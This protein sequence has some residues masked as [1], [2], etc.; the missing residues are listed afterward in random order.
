MSKAE[1]LPNEGLTATF[2]VQ[3][4]DVTDRVNAVLND[5]MSED[6]RSKAIRSISQEIAQEAKG[7]SHY[8]TFVRSFFHG[9]EFYLFHGNLQ[10]RAAGRRSTG[11]RGQVR[12]RYGQLDVAPAHRR[13]LH[14]WDLFRPGRKTSGIQRRQYS[15]HRVIFFP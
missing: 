9:N 3:V 15:R 2:L 10:G 4:E 11:V 1:E 6:E 13:L 14:L 8:D 12:R 7:D 5:E